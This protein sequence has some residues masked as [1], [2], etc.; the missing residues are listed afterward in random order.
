MD[1]QHPVLPEAL[2]VNANNRCVETLC[3]PLGKVKEK[4]VFW[5][6]IPAFVTI[7]ASGKCPS[8]SLKH[9]GL[10]PQTRLESRSKLTLTWSADISQKNGKGKMFK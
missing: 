10:L 8:I 1:Q 4:V 7:N 9:P 5:L 3:L 6:K 2:Y